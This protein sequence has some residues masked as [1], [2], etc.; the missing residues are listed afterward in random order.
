MTDWDI[1]NFMIVTK[2]LNFE[3]LVQ[4]IYTTEHTGCNLAELVGSL[5]RE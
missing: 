1:I 5:H 3:C 4:A 2:I